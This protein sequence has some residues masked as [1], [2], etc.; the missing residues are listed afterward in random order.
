MSWTIYQTQ[1]GGDDDGLLKLKKAIEHAGSK[2]IIM[3]CASE[4]SGYSSYRKPYPA[5]GCDLRFMKRVGSAGV[6]G[7][8]SD[9]VNP[10]QVDYLFPGEIATQHQGCSGSSAATALAAGLAGLILWCSALQSSAAVEKPTKPVPNVGT[11]RGPDSFGGSLK[12]VNSGL[13]PADHHGKTATAAQSTPERA[14]FQSHS[15]MF[16]LFDTL[17]SSN[18]NPLVNITAQLYEAANMSNPA[19]EL[20]EL[21]KLKAHEFFKKDG[22]ITTADR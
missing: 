16:G 11:R 22:T 1:S 2:N 19:K 20:I 7:E 3:F 5:T 14:D 12:R 10:D 18:E 8:R 13:P 9:Y 17:R 4:D 15:R 21:C 6:Y